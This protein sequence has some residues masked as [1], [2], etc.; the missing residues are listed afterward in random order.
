MVTTAP[1]AGQGPAE[2]GG[3]KGHGAESSTVLEAARAAGING[4]PPMVFV[5]WLQ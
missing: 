1:A 2:G 4:S 5:L 3:W